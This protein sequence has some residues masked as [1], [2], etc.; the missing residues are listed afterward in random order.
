MMSGPNFQTKMA[1][2]KS[3]V[4]AIEFID[5][6]NTNLTVPTPNNTTSWDVSDKQDGSVIAWLDGTKLYIGGQGGV[7]ANQNLSHLFYEFDNL[8]SITFNDNF[9]T[10]KTTDMSYM[11]AASEAIT[12]FDLSSFDTSKVTNMSLMFAGWNDI[13]QTKMSL[14]SIN[15]S[16][17]D[18]NNV[19]TMEAMFF[20]CGEITTLDISNFD[21]HNVTNMREMFNMPND[22]SA[23]LETIIF[24]DDWNTSKVTNMGYMFCDNVSLTDIDLTKFDT[25]KVIAMDY[26]FSRCKSLTELNLNSFDTGNVENIQAFVSNCSNLKTIYATE[27]FVTTNITVSTN[28]FYN[29]INLVGGNGTIFDSSKIDK[30]YAKIDKENQSGYFTDGTFPIIDR[31]NISASANSISLV[32]ESYTL[33]DS[34]ITKYEFSNDGGNTWIDNGTNNVYQF[35]GLN[36][37]TTYSI[38]VRVTSSQNKQ[39]VLHLEDDSCPYQEGK[40]WNFPYT[41]GQQTFTS[42]CYGTYSLEA[43]GAQGGNVTS[44]VGG[45]GGYATGNKILNYDDK[46]YIYVGGKGITT[47]S[48]SGAAGSSA[49]KNGGYN[50]GG[51]GNVANCNGSIRYGASGGGATHFA[52]KSDLLKD[53]STSPSAVLLVGGGGGGAF[54]FDNTNT[55]AYGVGGVAGGLT[56]PT[57]TF[58]L[59]T[60]TKTHYAGGGSQSAGGIGGNSYSDGLPESGVFGQGGNYIGGACSN[61][62]GGGSGYYGG[63]SC[64]FGPGAGGSSYIGGVTNGT[65]K[66]GSEAMPK[67][68]G[69]TGTMTGNTDDGYARISLGHI[70]ND[71]P[72]KKIPAPTYDLNKNVVVVSFPIVTLNDGTNLSCDNGFA[73]FYTKDNGERI[74]ITSESNNATLTNNSINVNVP[75]NAKGVVLSEIYDYEIDSG[76]HENIT[77]ILNSSSFNFLPTAATIFYDNSKTHLDCNNVQCALDEIKEML[78]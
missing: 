39:K 40:T 60:H 74:R 4:T 7:I 61:G 18:T 32:V 57:V 20:N 65:T 37:N 10:S 2:V 69:T 17:F 44:Y 5:L 70:D 63:G 19:T 36:N 13:D 43:W 50:G 68:D 46:L 16:S 34:E 26:M 53:L 76:G 23:K 62:S 33:D 64:G 51:S 72:T 75:F 28:M 66:A 52:T 12:T 73:C 55:G 22:E 41:G 30:E 45:K 48:Y 27:D 9:D 15:L 56:A 47:T 58:T 31:V 35:T 21:T 6:G 78:D 54:R 38:Y 49:L 29:D 71:I 24:G 8:V 1:S 3:T 25:S 67:H 59:A 42:E 14:T 11:F 77:N